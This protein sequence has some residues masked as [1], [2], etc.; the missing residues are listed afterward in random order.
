LSSPGD[1]GTA[2]DAVKSVVT[3]LNKA[4]GSVRLEL[5][6]SE[7]V[8]GGATPRAQAHINEHVDGYDIYL[9][10]MWLKF[11]SQT[12]AFGSGTEEE[13]ERALKGHGENGT[14]AEVMFFF[15][16]EMPSRL[17]DI[18]PA[19]FER[20]RAFRKRVQKD[21]YTKEFGAAAELAQILRVDLQKVVQRLLADATTRSDAVAPSQSS[22]PASDDDGII[23]LIAKAE[24]DA[25]AVRDVIED[26]VMITVGVSAKMETRTSEL[27]QNVASGNRTQLIRTM[28]RFARDLGQF[29]DALFAAATP[30]SDHIEGMMEAFSR[31]A[32]L[33][34]AMNP[35]NR[36]E[37]DEVKLV[38]GL[39]RDKIRETEIGLRTGLTAV[40]SIPSMTRNLILARTRA[41]AAIGRLAKE[42]S[43][44]VERLSKAVE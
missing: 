44:A 32:S 13:F 30:F 43:L 39:M 6:T 25:E 37:V 21:V 31:A 1:L 41:I 3:E 40:E 17:D 22:L 11:G 2:R 35:E 29:S 15:C 9:G 10:L 4:L 23:E 16:T 19:S 42:F 28:D 8:P 33:S 12:G 7:D 24:K 18:D 27:Q 36:A 5:V 14:P 20:V 26:V 38:I 34:I